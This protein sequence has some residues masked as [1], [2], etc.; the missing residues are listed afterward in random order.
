MN[1]IGLSVLV[2]EA[3]AHIALAV[4]ALV[5]GEIEKAEYQLG[6]ISEAYIA[7]SIANANETP[8]QQKENPEDNER[9]EA[10]EDDKGKPGI[11]HCVRP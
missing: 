7:W 4:A 5:D 11:G 8:D 6:Q 9:T 1:Y 10:I 3:K 2:S